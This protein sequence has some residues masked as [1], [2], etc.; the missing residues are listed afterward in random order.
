MPAKCLEY[1]YVCA[2]EQMP[3]NVLKIGETHT[4]APSKRATQFSGV[5]GL[6]TWR[7]VYA[8]ATPNSKFTEAMVHRRLKAMA[9][10]YQK[11]GELFAITATEALS[12]IEEC[13]TLT[14]APA[15]RALVTTTDVAVPKARGPWACALAMP[16]SSTLHPGMTLSRAMA[17]VAKG[18][19]ALLKRL[20]AGGIEMVYPDANE[21]YFRF[22]A[23]TASPLALW[24][25]TQRL[26][27]LA[28]GIEPDSHRDVCCRIR[29][30]Q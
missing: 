16:I 6:V 14:P 17:L 27:W 28:L 24:L 19:R 10:T 22:H 11:R 7:L 4:Q 1:V 13:V 18:D 23:L 20:T 25:A 29:N 12:I 26:T 9:R 30:G 21:P 3:A 5:D 2:S 8:V 15:P